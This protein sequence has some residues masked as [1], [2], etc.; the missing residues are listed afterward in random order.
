V[1]E[2]VVLN[3]SE[4]RRSLGLAKAAFPHFFHWGHNN[5]VSE[6]Y[7]GFSLWGEFVPDPNDPAP[8]YFFVT[9]DAY[10]ASWAGHL[11]IGQH[12]Y[13]WS[14][15]DFGDA[16]RLDT[17]ACPSLQDAIASLKQQMTDL[18]TALLGSIN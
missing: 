2:E 17:G 3:E 7:S 14:S 16:R 6:S 11:S 8:R 4:I 10:R 18:F 13:F 5:E 1:E 12:C 15:A 9:F